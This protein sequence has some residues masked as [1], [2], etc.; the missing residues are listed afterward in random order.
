ML[1]A[2]TLAIKEASREGAEARALLE[3]I[4]RVFGIRP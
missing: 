4:M 2:P 3:T 1:H